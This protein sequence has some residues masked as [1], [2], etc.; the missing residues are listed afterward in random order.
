MAACRGLHGLPPLEE[1]E[2][3]D[4]A[5][6]RAAH[7]HRWPH[8]IIAP[9]SARLAAIAI[10]AALAIGYGTYAV[11]TEPSTSPSTA[12]TTTSNTDASPNE[13]VQR[14]IDDWA[15]QG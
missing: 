9:R 1:R 11:T 2:E 10:A 14:L 8:D 7:R 12:S 3:R 5:H 4:R 6:P 13:P 15:R